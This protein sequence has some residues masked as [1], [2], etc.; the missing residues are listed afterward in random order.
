MNN[1]V[2]LAIQLLH[3]QIVTGLAG[4]DLLEDGGGHTG[5]VGDQATTH[6]LGD[7]VLAS[8]YVPV[9]QV[10]HTVAVTCPLLTDVLH[11]SLS[12]VTVHVGSTLIELHIR[13]HDD[14]LRQFV[15]AATIVQCGLQQHIEGGFDIGVLAQVGAV[16]AVDLIAEVHAV[17]LNQTRSP[18]ERN[19]VVSERTVSALSAVQTQGDSDVQRSC[20]TTVPGHGSGGI[21]NSQTVEGLAL[22]VVSQILPVLIYHQTIGVIHRT[23][24]SGQGLGDDL[25]RIQSLGV[26]LSL[27]VLCES[28]VG[29]NLGITLHT[30][31]V[32]TSKGVLILQ[33][34]LGR[35][36]VE[37]DLIPATL[38]H[39]TLQDVDAGTQNRQGLT[40]LLGSHANE[41]TNLGSGL[42]SLLGRS[43]L[44]RHPFT[45]QRRGLTLDV[46]SQ[47]MLDDVQSIVLQRSA[48][49]Y[50][51]VIPATEL[52]DILQITTHSVG[53]VGS[54]ILGSNTEEPALTLTTTHVT[55]I[56]QTLQSIHRVL[57]EGVLEQQHYI[58]VSARTI[59][60]TH[61]EQV[62]QTVHGGLMSQST[63]LSASVVGSGLHTIQKSIHN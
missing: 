2:T 35:D 42:T 28:L 32:V 63:I 25:V 60:C 39:Q 5:H 10:R 1:G 37:L 62:H 18:R 40:I 41:L 33:T 9:N 8:I 53:I 52:R 45:Q 26:N 48:D 43:I 30:L 6:I 50:E 59:S 29:F 27:G 24:A 7:I 36:L 51:Q 15:L 44:G 11:E 3:H 38:G 57:V 49:E 17:G 47:L 4:Q 20:L 16:D 58:L 55:D 31:N 34:S 14:I 46:Q 61:S 56:E 21:N 22:E 23:V 12:V 19:V 54:Q 13:N